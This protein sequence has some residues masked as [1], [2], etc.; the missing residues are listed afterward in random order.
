MVMLALILLLVS[1]PFSREHK[2]CYAYPTYAF[3]AGQSKLPYNQLI[4]RHS[5]DSM[6]HINNSF[7]RMK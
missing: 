5:A 6:A 4:W 7:S 2:S 1:G 3:V